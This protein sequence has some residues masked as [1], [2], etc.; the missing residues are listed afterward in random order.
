MAAS[1]EDVVKQLKENQKIDSE[2]QSR[3]A[4]ITRLQNSAAKKENSEKLKNLNNEIKLFSVKT[5]ANGKKL[6]D[7]RKNESKLALLQLENEKKNLE[8]SMQQSQ[9]IE[10]QKSDAK[11]NLELQREALNKVREGIEA[12]GFVADDDNEYKRKEAKLRIEELKLQRENVPYFSEARKRLKA[13]IKENKRAA[14][15]TTFLGKIANSFTGNKGKEEERAKEQSN[16][17]NKMLSVLGNISSGITGLAKGTAAKVGKLAKGG[18]MGLVKGTLFAG[19]FFLISEFLSSPAF[20]KTA[21]FIGEK[22]IPALTNFYN[23]VIKPAFDAVIDFLMNDAFPAIGKFIS[24]TVLPIL[25]DFYENILKPTFGFLI[26]FFKESIW[27]TMKEFI[28]GSSETIKKFYEDTLKPAFTAIGE[29][30]TNQFFPALGEIFQKLKDTYTKI[31]PS[32]DSL[33]EFLKETTLPVL[34][35]TAKKVFADVKDIVMKVID[36]A[37]NI[38]SGDFGAAF[39]DLMDIGGAI[40]RAIDNAISGILKAVG[41]DF[42]G[43]ISDVIGNFFTGIYDSITGTVN[44]IMNSIEGIIRAVPGI[45]DTVADTLF[46]EMTPQEIAVRDMKKVE[47]E[48]AKIREEI[49][50]Q[51]ELLAGGDERAGALSGFAKREDIIKDLQKQIAEQDAEAARLKAIA[52]PETV[53]GYDEAA[54]GQ[55]NNPNADP[56]KKMTKYEKIKARQEEKRQR[57]QTGDYTSATG[58]AKGGLLGAG[59][60]ALVGENGPELIFSRTDAQVKTSQQTDALLNAAANNNDKQ[61]A[62]VIVNAPTVAP[63]TQNISNSTSTISYIGNPDPIFQRASAFAI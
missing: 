41:L 24:E 32:L 9:S 18:L 38:I 27:P 15:D 46:G 2:N 13:E 23:D 47:E 37:G 10:I 14:R 25:K 1:F 54:Y 52:E 16:K 34:F 11:L 3:Q 43:N 30:A 22:V 36:F 20:A 33:F 5:D 39:D 58:F 19:L 50:N 62:P 56:P 12:E 45:G 63:S 4:E 7:M 8:Q 31:K 55:D 53:E 44:G 42:E 29:F 57:M 60:L 40:A 28:S 17:D 61:S 48:K 6:N 49:A 51:Q 35:D 21:K 26:D 59:R